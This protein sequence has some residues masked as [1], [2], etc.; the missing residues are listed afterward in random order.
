MKKKLSLRCSQ[1][2]EWFMWV[3]R[4]DNATCSRVEM[5]AQ[6]RNDSLG[7]VILSQVSVES[8]E[9]GRNCHRG[10]AEST[11]RIGKVGRCV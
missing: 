11:M 7:K 10:K 1:S 2:I 6:V 4:G 9:R 5:A 3:R 8:P